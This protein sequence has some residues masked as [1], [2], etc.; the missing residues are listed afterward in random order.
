MI[1]GSQL[2]IS[3]AGKLNRAADALSKNNWTMNNLS[4]F[5]QQAPQAD[6]H[7]WPANVNLRFSLF[8]HPNLL[9]RPEEYIDCKL[10]MAVRI[11]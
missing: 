6:P 1:F 7:A 11:Q 8:N 5:F 4:V 2:F 10:L 3:H 9:V